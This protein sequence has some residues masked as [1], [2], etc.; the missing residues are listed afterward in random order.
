MYFVMTQQPT[1]MSPYFQ[2]ACISL[3]EAHTK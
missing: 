3:L 2:F 1:D